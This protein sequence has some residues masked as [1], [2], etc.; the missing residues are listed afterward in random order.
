MKIAIRNCTHNNNHSQKFT[1]MVKAKTK[2]RL[3]NKIFTFSTLKGRNP[4]YRIDVFSMA[5]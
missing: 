1:N 3:E 5:L 2:N 4:K